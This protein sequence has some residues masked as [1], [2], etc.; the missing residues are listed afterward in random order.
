MCVFGYFFIV[1]VVVCMPCPPFY[2]LYLFYSSIWNKVGIISNTTT[3]IIV[4]SVWN[5]VFF[6][7]FFYFIILF[8]FILW[9]CIF[10]FFL[11]LSTCARIENLISIAYIAENI[12]KKKKKFL[13]NSN[14]KIKLILE[15]IDDACTILYNCKYFYHIKLQRKKKRKNKVNGKDKRDRW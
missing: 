15:S 3:N 11:S 8:H 10:C 2:L 14:H 6:L 5:F 1:F 12:L 4:N 7:K 13:F 9:Y